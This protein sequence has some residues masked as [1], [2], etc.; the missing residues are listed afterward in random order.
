[1][2]RDG[3][4]L[5]HKYLR[6]KR[7][8]AYIEFMLAVF[9]LALGSAA[10]LGL[11]CMAGQ[12]CKS[13]EYYA[14]AGQIARTEM[15]TIRSTRACLLSNRTNAVLISQP[16]ALSE[17]PSGA[18]TLTITDSAL[19]TGAKEITVTLRWLQSPMDGF[20]TLTLKTMV[21]PDGPTS[22]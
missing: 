16:T 17:L 11:I 12:T 9:I 4:L 20:K 10:V 5:K 1:M 15:E 13:N 21:S 19:L 18:A 2:E 8:A 7:G 14:L 6:C 3:G 22:S